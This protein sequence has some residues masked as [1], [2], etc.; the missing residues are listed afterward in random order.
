MNEFIPEGGLAAWDYSNMLAIARFMYSVDML[1]NTEMMQTYLFANDECKRLFKSWEEFTHS[2]TIGAF[3]NAFTRDTSYNINQS[4][5]FA[6]NVGVF[7]M[8]T[9]TG[10]EWLG[11]I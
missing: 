10:F 6:I 3:Y 11:H 8:Q 7:C 5:R 1:S 4:A 2:L 9:Y